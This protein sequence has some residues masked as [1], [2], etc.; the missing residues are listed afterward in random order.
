LLDLATVAQALQ[1]FSGD[2]QRADQLASALGFTPVKT[3]ADLLGG[4]ATPLRRFFEAQTD[5]FGIGELYRVGSMT[6]DGSTVGMYVGILDAWGVRSTDRDR[7][8]RRMARALVE[9]TTDFRTMFILVPNRLQPER[10]RREAEFVFPRSFVD[11]KRATQTASSLTTIRALVDLQDPT[12]FHRE[13]LRDLA[14]EAGMSLPAISQRWQQAFSVERATKRFY[15]DYARVRDELARVL[16][17]SNPDHA[18]IRQLSDDEA[19]AWAT[20]QLGR[21][22]FLWF[23]QAKRWLGYEDA[24]E[25]SPT[26]L[27]DLWNRRAAAPGG[28]YQGMLKPLFFDAMA[29]RNPGQQIRDLLG[30]TPYLNGGL[31]R[32]NALEDRIDAAGPVTIPD[33][34]FDPDSDRTSF[35]LLRSY[36]FTTR[37]S[38]P[39][40]QSVDP[41]PELLGRVFENLYQGD[42]RHDSGTYYTPREIVHFMCR[43]ALDGYLR[44]TAN[45]DQ[46]TIEWLRGLVT[47]QEDG[48]RRLDQ[49]TAQG[50]TTALENVR[51][52]DPAVG[53]GAF[54]LG[55]MQEI[56]QLRRGLLHARANY[57]EDEQ[58][59]IAAWKRHAIQW[60]LYGV[61]INPEAVEI[62]QLRL[63]LSLVLDM[64]DPRSVEPLPNL[65]FRIVA[66]D[67]LVDRA[68]EIVF[69]ESLGGRL[70][71]RIR[72]P[73]IERQERYIAQWRR[74]FE[75]TQENPAQLRVL[76][77]KIIHAYQEIIRLQVTAELEQ[78]REEAR[79][80]A[81]RAGVTTRASLQNAAKKAHARV[82]S[83]EELAQSQTVDAR[84]QKPFLWPVAFKEVFD[85]GGF[86]LVL[87]NPPYV[88]QEK[89]SASDQ[90]TYESAFPDVHAST[91][92]LYVYFYA[93]ALQITRPGGWLSFITSDKFM[94]ADYGA[95]L[96]QLLARDVTIYDL[97]DFAHLPV[98]DADVMP[99]VLVAKNL[100]ADEG[101]QLRFAR[102]RESMRIAIAAAKRPMTVE[103]VRIELEALYGYLSECLLS[104]IEQRWLLGQDVWSFAHPAL[105]KLY[106]ELRQKNDTLGA[107]LGS[108]NS[109][110]GIKTGLNEAYVVDTQTQQALLRA[111]KHSEGFIRPWARGQDIHRYTVIKPELALILLKSSGDLDNDAPWRNESNAAEA[112]S[113]LAA[114]VPAI[115]SHMVKYKE[116]RN[117]KGKTVGL[118][119]RSDQGRFWWELRSCAYYPEF[120]KPKMVWKDI[121]YFP[122]FAWDTSETYYGNTAFFS[123]S[124]PKWLVAV[125]NSV[126]FS[127]LA[128][129]SLFEAKDAYYRWLPSDLAGIPIPEV[130]PQLAK[131]L[132]EL[133]DM[134]IRTTSEESIS[135]E[136]DDI[137]FELYGVSQE[138]RELMLHWYEIRRK[139]ETFASMAEHEED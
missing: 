31:F 62:C 89:L 134:A 35:N 105:L 107:L 49:A 40:D 117:K 60:G 59:Q 118:A 121:S 101:H 100:P 114:Y 86:D 122:H 96:R 38:T 87:A 14:I 42:E 28:F 3:P 7:A 29:R 11:V 27:M 56:V 48:D 5:R 58:S 127:W 129:M 63:W 15:Q 64:W 125:C 33:E 32:G 90:S 4:G 128:S 133:V 71:A 10:V 36:R 104:G 131:R 37:E 91:S 110:Y 13:L 111:D 12:R 19:K 46:E 97:I 73:A 98:F 115:Y 47:E 135:Q 74:E 17:S 8:R 123:S 80:A 53:S 106:S 138:L 26:Y 65:D 50:L 82:T 68:G 41:D 69:A 55:A 51:I 54:L 57:T 92:D 94:R 66:G 76:R 43:Q 124:A 9:Y 6:A 136:V 109:T 116:Y 93:R 30:Y 52:C 21:I 112:E 25:G 137:C 45:V 34:A 81:A 61:D 20:R 95:G 88:R 139:S 22:L 126:P 18:V 23:L 113:Q 99:S 77:D 102:L 24:G 2:P 67:S 119:R 84:Y 120:K 1:D 130:S 103:S 78:A 39:D 70:Q 79:I 132:E 83:L 108:V 85:D 72:T 75:A 16:K 44:D